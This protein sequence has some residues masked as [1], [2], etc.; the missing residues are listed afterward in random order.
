MSQDT[1]HNLLFG[2]FAVQLRKLT[3]GQILEAAAAW[4]T[5]QSKD[6]R[7]RLVSSEALSSK[8]GALIERLVQEAI[9]AHDG[10]LQATLNTFGGDEAIYETFQGSIGRTDSGAVTSTLSTGTA[11]TV[12]IENVPA[13]LESPGRY[14][15]EHLHAQGGMGRIKLVHDE[16]LRRDV[17]LKELPVEGSEERGNAQ[18]GVTP[19]ST[20][21]EA[22][23]L[24]EARI[25]GQLEHPSIVPVYELGHR[26]DRTLYYT[27]KFVRGETLEQ[28]IRGESSL[29]GRLLLLPHFVDLCQAVAYAHDRGVIHRDLKP[30]NVM[31]GTFGETML[32][33]WGL[34]KARGLE[35]VHASELAHTLR[36]ISMGKV[37]GIANTVY[38][39]I[40]GTPSYMPPEQAKGLLDQVD[41]CSD[42]YSLGAIL[43]QIITGKP[44]F[45]GKNA[46][47]VIQKVKN[48]SPAPIKSLVRR[49]P[50][51][52]IRICERAMHPD[53][54]RRFQS[55]KELAD[56]IQHFDPAEFSLI[57]IL[58]ITTR[59][60]ELATF[61][62]REV[63]KIRRDANRK[64]RRSNF[65][66]YLLR[67]LR[68][69]LGAWILSLYTLLC[70]VVPVALLAMAKDARDYE[71][72]LYFIN[73]SFDSLS[74]IEEN[75]RELGLEPTSP[76]G[77]GGEK[78]VW[79]VT[80]DNQNL[81][82]G[83]YVFLYI[84]SI[85]FSVGFT[86]R[87][88]NLSAPWIREVI[89]ERKAAAE[90]T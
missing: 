50:R 66:L 44:P 25:T 29:A 57:P 76:Y 75:R 49:A 89:A 9:D 32:I 65:R 80:L 63:K 38:G 22:R 15:R 27:M 1:D 45:S 46:W 86:A 59:I 72:Q 54:S 87:M 37:E 52:L 7:E 39:Q 64:L 81:I 10:D 90:S 18:E 47:E 34:A 68:H 4:A 85:F 62:P 2:V 24:Q 79:K 83:L 74:G 56:R 42:V 23:F 30:S 8:D 84:V 40:L 3:P 58:S 41:E 71:S 82:I 88:E 70:F 78:A 21:R 60:P 53:K 77:E 43:Y 16:Y 11:G 31:V 26:A 19:I 55:A 14:T 51:E 5:D 69:G 48:D 33:D 12:A 61:T 17:A 6:L 36:H 73:R 67:T 20:P 13:V 28:R 35:D